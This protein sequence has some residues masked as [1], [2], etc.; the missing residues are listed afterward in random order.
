MGEAAHVFT[1][2]LKNSVTRFV[3]PLRVIDW[4]MAPDCIEGG[5]SVSVPETR[6]ALAAVQVGPRGRGCSLSL[7]AIPHNAP[8]TRPPSL[9][10]RK[11]SHPRLLRKGLPGHP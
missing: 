10:G 4:R 11:S 8:H 7:Y 2:Y 5:M 6:L 9:A 3:E 1:A